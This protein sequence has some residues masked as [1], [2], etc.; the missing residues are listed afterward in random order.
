[1]KPKSVPAK[2]FLV[3]SLSFFMVASAGAERY[4]PKKSMAR[5][6]GGSKADTGAWPWMA[7]LVSGPD[8]YNDQVCGAALIDPKWVITAAHCANE[9]PYQ[10]LM[11]VDNLSET[12]VRLNVKNTYIHSEYFN[13]NGMVVPDIALLELETAATQTPISLYRGTDTLEGVTATII[14]WGTTV[15]DPPSFPHDLMEAQ[16]PIVSNDTCNVP[17]GGIITD[18]EFCAGFEDGRVDTCQGDSGGPVMILDGGTWKL[19]GIV[20]WGEGCAQPT[21]YGVYTRI[22]SLL[23]WID[24]TMNPVPGDYNSN[25]VL[26]LDDS[27]G[28]LQE[29]TGLR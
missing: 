24:A 19:A 11:G 26:G 20:S 21:Y 14:G 12:G 7:S 13:S 23:D 3:I 10:V 1:M 4:K 18:Y 27:I 17:Y 2:L 28:I 6:V 22:T 25:G 29:L 8:N 16:V 5:I 15:E 9:P